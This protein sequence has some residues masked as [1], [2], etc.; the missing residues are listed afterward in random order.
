MRWYCFHL[1]RSSE[2]QGKSLAREV[3]R[4]HS[5]HEHT[6]EPSEVLFTPKTDQIGHLR[7]YYLYTVD[8]RCYK[9]IIRDF[10]GR[11]GVPPPSADLQHL[12]GDWL[13]PGAET[14]FFRKETIPHAKPHEDT[15]A[16][17]D[18]ASKSRGRKE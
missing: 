14:E 18:Q 9:D 4:I 2:R 12:A 5:S 15:E 3:A 7:S 8:A 11:I 16:D 13:V 1:G 17:K 6:A 10:G